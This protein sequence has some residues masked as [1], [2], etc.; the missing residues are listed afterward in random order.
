MKRPRFQSVTVDV[1]ESRYSAIVRVYPARAPAHAGADSP[2]FM[3]PGER[4][5]A[6]VMRI[7]L[8]AVDVTDE[9]L[10]F[11]RSAIEDAVKEK[12]K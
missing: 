4:A 9:I 2:R 11:T 3:D 5:H 12:V 7:L 1:G 8:G 10:P 6:Q